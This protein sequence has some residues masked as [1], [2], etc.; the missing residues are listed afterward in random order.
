MASIGQVA[1]IL[2]V[3]VSSL[4]RWERE[5]I[6]NKPSR[7]PTDRRDYSNEDIE[8]IRQFLEKKRK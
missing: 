8:A 5:G 1:W 4:R 6:L 7:T 2:N 3:S